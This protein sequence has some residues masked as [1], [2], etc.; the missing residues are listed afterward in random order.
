MGAGAVDVVAEIDR[1]VSERV[2]SLTI[3]GPAE[4]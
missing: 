2:S 1:L 4:R 3:R